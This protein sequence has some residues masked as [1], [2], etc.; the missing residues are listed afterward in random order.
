[1]TELSPELLARYGNRQVPRYT[2]YPTAPHFRPVEEP[3]LGRRWLGDLPDNEPVSLYLHVPFCRA[4]CWYCGC[5]TSVTR[6]EEPI[7]S[8]VETLLREIELVAD[9]LPARVPVAHVHFGGGTPTVMQPA[10][11]LKLMASLRQHFDVRPDAEI[12]VEI[13]PRT[14]SAEMVD[15]LAESGFTRASLGVQSFDPVV[16]R[17]INRVQPFEQT[18]RAVDLLRA[19]GIGRIN[20]DL[21]YG[22][23]EQTVDSCLDTVEQALRLEPDRLAVFGY[24]HVPGFKRHQRKIDAERLPGSAERLAQSQAIAAALVEGG[25]VQIGLDHFAAPG[26]E[27]TLAASRGALHRNFQ[28]YTTDACRTLLGLGASAIGQL[29]SGFV[30]NAVLT[31]DYQRRIAAGELATAR[32][33]PTNAD[34]RLRGAI[35]E[36]LMCDYRV[37]LARLCA[38]FGTDPAQL[39]IE[40]GLRELAS[41]GLVRITG[42]LVEVD[43]AARPLV[44]TV[45]A[46]FDTYLDQGAGRHARAI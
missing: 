13:D 31:G 42:D 28:G 23:P 44:R 36:R 1:M 12:A 5:H 17:A 45:A 26:D 10:Q 19:A 15:A 21:I 30:Q 9:A 37:D 38:Q 3:Q 24:A 16:Q 25:L 14:L 41:D 46:A 34:D 6:R 8:Y 29:P 33:C 43:R 4:M 40:G 32:H 11:L 20:L 35:I 27:L 22:L 18:A 2:S 7:A 39:S